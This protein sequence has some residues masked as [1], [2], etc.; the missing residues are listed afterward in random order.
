MILSSEHCRLSVGVMIALTC[1][2][3]NAR[4]SV[5]PREMQITN[6]PC[7]RRSAALRVHTGVVHMQQRGSCAPYPAIFAVSGES[8]GCDILL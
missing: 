6:R 2:D 4:S 7:A 3:P 8:Y 5:L 1:T